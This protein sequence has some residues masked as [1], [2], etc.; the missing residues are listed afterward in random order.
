[1]KDL[2]EYVDLLDEPEARQ[3]ALALIMAKSVGAK[4]D[5]DLVVIAEYILYGVYD[6]NEGVDP[7]LV[8]VLDELEA[9]G[10]IER[11]PNEGATDGR[12]DNS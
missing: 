8:K 5:T 7:N 9:D 3:R 12:V 1:M 4:S 10:M 2:H 11:V 6:E